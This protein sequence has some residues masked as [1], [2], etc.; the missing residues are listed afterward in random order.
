MTGQA[1]TKTMI[2][3]KLYELSALRQLALIPVAVVVW[4]VVYELVRRKR[5]YELR[6][7]LPELPIAGA[8]DGE[9][10]P[11]LRAMYRNTQ[12]IRKSTTEAYKYKDT[13]VIFPI[14]DLGNV[15]I[16]PPKE[17]NWFLDETD[18]NLDFH[19]HMLD[20]FQLGRTLTEPA[21]M[22]DRRPV[23]HALISTKLTQEIA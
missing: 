21:I 4:L 18:D 11:K 1:L 5:P 22:H 10:F 9:W 23:H 16:V 20:A 15:V 6:P 19:E 7:R 13:P 17:V 2:F 3:E 14:L 12:D 8:R